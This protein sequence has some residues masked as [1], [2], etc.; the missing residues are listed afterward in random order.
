MQLKLVYGYRHYFLTMFFHERKI[1]VQYFY[2]YT[3]PKKLNLRKENKFA[4]SL[5][6]KQNIMRMGHLLS[7]TGIVLLLSGLKCFRNATATVT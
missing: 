3:I 2:S 7:E 1:E 4:R 6:T 5:S